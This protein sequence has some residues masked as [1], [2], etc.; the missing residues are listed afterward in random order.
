MLLACLAVGLISCRDTI[1]PREAKPLSQ[2]Q[3]QEGSGPITVLRLTCTFSFSNGA[4]GEV[5]CGEPG[6]GMKRV[7]RSEILPASSEYAAWLPY[8]LVK[9]TVTETWSFH[10][11]VQNLLGQPI[12]TLDGT[13]AVGAKVAVT[14]GPVASAGTGTVS[15]LN[16]DGAGTFTAPNQPYFDYPGIVARGSYSTYRTWEVHVPNTVTGVTMGVAISTDFP[17][18]QNVAATPPDSV[19]SWFSSDTGM[20]GPTDSIGFRFTKNV[21]RVIFT[22]SSTIADRQLAVALV[23]GNVIG[24]EPVERGSGVYYLWVADDGTGSQLW[25]ITR[26]LS[27]LPQVRLAMPIIGL[28]EMYLRPE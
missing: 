16:A 14:Y 21:V 15:L 17:A 19:P 25:T 2:V 13:T 26:R 8:H 11:V 6:S 10:S 24:G 5:R 18:E 7:S 1:D 20:V 9:D 27:A 28:S 22:D 3:Q 12:G 4:Q 23:N